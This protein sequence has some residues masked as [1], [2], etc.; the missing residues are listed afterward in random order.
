MAWVEILPRYRELFRRRGWNSATS[1]LDWSGILVNLH[2]QRQV[3]WVKLDDNAE[4]GRFFLKKQHAVS[5]RERSRN[6]WHG[7]GWS[8]TAVREARLLQSLRRA[9]IG[10]PDV[11]AFGEENRRAFLLLQ[12]ES[13]MTELRTILQD[14]VSTADR[15]RLAC[16]L[17][18]ELARIHD[19]GFDH[20]DLFAKHI[21]VAGH[22]DAFRISVLDWQRSR[23]RPRVSWRL[24]CR[25]LAA[26]DATLHDALASDG[27][28]LRCLRAY[29]RA[30][31]APGNAPPLCRLAR[32][33][34]RAAVAL[35]QRRNIREIGQLPIPPAQQQ[36]VPACAGRLLVVRSYFEEL[37]QQLPPW[38]T[39]LCGIG[40]QSCPSKP[41]R[42]GILSHKLVASGENHGWQLPL[43]AHTLFRLH[44]FGVA[45]PR[46]LAVA[47]SPSHVS[48]ITTAPAIIS[49][50][51]AFAQASIRSRLE[52]MRQAR[53]II[54]QVG[55]AG[56]RLPVDDAWPDRLRIDEATG[57]VIFARVEPLEDAHESRKRERRAAA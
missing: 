52:L 55:V 3:E 23:R 9:G 2:R 20:P 8:A 36:F 30:L 35:K 24:R 33:V 51:E 18:R 14:L 41:D 1:F 26:L 50:H 49:W 4:Q 11:V 19:A 22:E 21:L 48:L 17:G 13:G 54:R 28:R 12:D 10:C 45:A 31:N 5:W 44:R 32:H 42:I 25:D 7:F 47:R 43:L 34:R 15:Q 16:A 46:L 57:T 29:R 39:N 27:L 40:F 56:Y 6:A 53:S 38:L 37:G